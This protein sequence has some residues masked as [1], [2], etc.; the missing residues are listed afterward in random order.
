MIIKKILVNNDR[1]FIED[2]KR[3]SE[4]MVI[5]DRSNAYLPVTKRK[6][7]KEAETK[8]IIYYLT[9]KIYK[10]GREVMVII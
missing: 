3:V 5:P 4:C 8:K 2:V 7:L 1:K 9:T 6:L 10:V